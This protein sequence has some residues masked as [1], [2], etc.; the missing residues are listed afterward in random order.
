[1]SIYL[2]VSNSLQPLSL[3]LAS[4][5]KETNA[6]PFTPQ[7][8]I[9]QTEGMNSWLKQQLAIENGIAAH[10]KFS[11]PNDII[12]SLCKLCMPSGKA[13]L[14]NETV[15]WTIYSLLGDDAFIKTFHQIAAYYSNNDI[16]RIALTDE[17]TDLFDQYQVY[18]HT[19]IHEWNTKIAIDGIEDWQEW[20][21]VAL[22]AKVV[23][24]YQDRTDTADALLKELKK[25]AT[26]QQIT[27]KIPSLY[28]F[29]IA[30]I[31]PFYLQLYHALAQFM[32]IHLYL[33]NPSPDQWWL[34]D[35][36]EKQIARLLQKKGIVKTSPA[37]YTVGNDL[38]MNWGA[39]V[40][41]S[42]GLLME[43]DDF[44]NQYDTA[45]AIPIHNPNS[46]LKKIQADIYQNAA[47]VDRN[48]ISAQDIEDGSITIN[49]AYTPVREVEVLYNYIASLIDQ[50]QVVLAP[51]DI[52]V[53]I[54]D[55]DLYA[56]Y[57]HA[58]FGNAPHKIP[59]TIADESYTSGVSLFNTLQ[60]LLSF[61]T[62]SFKAE[63]VLQLLDAPLIRKRFK[64]DEVSFLRDTIRQAGIIYSKDGRVADE[65]RTISWNYG[66]KKI[67]YG[68][69]MSG[70]CEVN[71][72][73]D[74][75]IPLDTMEG[76]EALDA[77]RLV[78][79]VKVLQRKME[80]RLQDKTIAEWAMYVQELV[81]DMI[82]VAGEGE[83]EEYAKF[84]QL[85]EALLMLEEDA[86]VKI[87]FEVFRYSFLKRLQVEQKSASFMKGGITFCSMVPMR[88][89]PFKVVA[90]LG[91]NFDKFPRKETAI[92]FSLLQYWKPGDRNV[93]NNDKHL[94]LETL[95]SAQQF[96]YISYI[97]VNAKDGASL[98]ASSLVDELIDYIARGY[99]ADT[100]RF[101]KE[102]VKIHPLHSFSH[103]YNPDGGLLNYLI[104]DRYKT[105]IVIQSATIHKKEFDFNRIAI[106]DIGKFLQNPPKLYLNKQ[107]NVYYH[108]DEVLLQEHELFELDS[109]TTW[110]LQDACIYLDEESA[111]AYYKKAK[112]EGKLPL[113]NMGKVAFSNMFNEL[114]DLRDRFQE[115]SMGNEM[116]SF[117]LSLHL[118]ASIID[119]RIDRVFGNKFISVCNSS[120]HLKYFLK[121]Y[122]RYLLL[123]ANGHALDMVFIAKKIKENVYIAAG[124]LSEKNAKDLL[125]YFCDCFKQGHDAYFYF[126]PALGLNNLGILS[127]DYAD[128]WSAYEEIKD[129]KQDYTFSDVYLE[130]AIEF[131]FFSEANYPLL[132]SSTKGI[133]DP[134]KDRLPALF[135]EIKK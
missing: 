128:F 18:R 44:V 106:D 6:N 123:V 65:T 64:L 111:T 70:E 104:D 92:S 108:E 84:I 90:M 41:E 94:F 2:N 127:D 38:L 59:Y 116:R 47:S 15:R 68:I 122:V 26:R 72:G 75:F 110:S 97:A 60:E 101:R 117:D 132:K 115:E 120:Q 58:V 96:L 27:N 83:D 67:I 7:W 113:H 71:D 95:L 78:Y 133:F 98:P 134:I 53:L 76:N 21:W 135:K 4:A 1:M 45:A 34:E 19:T 3:Q 11:K 103:Q 43:Q 25:E 50:K 69:C 100:D 88:S 39:L 112:K 20:L 17:L 102:W 14:T 10:I 5:L 24:H 22:R 57:I 107:L 89:I 79:F 86:T 77:V 54:S 31:T 73:V 99:H 52:V 56:P 8:V 61:D 12:A 82:V 124:E 118:D 93:K 49:G 105:G 74:T 29:G 36:S 33:V 66:L 13:M 42:F 16:K 114:S 81:E 121:D 91:M 51:K 62:N 85:T 30:V 48:S 80:A 131:G 125:S 46:L 130:K 40:K 28:L 63:A 9:T 35:K 129:K 55:V 32:D 126:Y 23:E 119:G 109:L 37:N 87:S